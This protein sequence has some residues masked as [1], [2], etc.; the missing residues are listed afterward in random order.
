MTLGGCGQGSSQC[1]VLYRPGSEDWETY[2]SSTWNVILLQTSA[3]L[4]QESQRIGTTQE[5]WVSCNR[6]SSIAP[7]RTWSINVIY[8]AFPIQSLSSVGLIKVFLRC[9]GASH[10][11]HNY[12]AYSLA[13]WSQDLPSGSQIP[14]ITK[15]S[16]PHTCQCWWLLMGLC[17]RAGVPISLSLITL[18]IKWR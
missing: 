8:S 5:K 17:S 11:L 3:H 7:L 16:H 2:S 18:F 4:I 13:L 14:H 12:P 1:L 9:M 15:V 6:I 10:T